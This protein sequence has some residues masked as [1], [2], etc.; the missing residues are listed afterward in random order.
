VTP[1]FAQSASDKAAAEALFD[2]GVKLLKAG[3]YDQAC[4]KLENSQR[5]DP[6]IGTLLYLGECYK[7]AGR[8]A[9][10]WAIF[11]EAASKAKAAGED[12]RARA[13][14]E[15][16]DALEGSLSRVTFKMADENK[17]IEGLEVH[18]GG[19]PV[20]RALWG[21]AV[22][23]DPGE[24]EVVVKAPGYEWFKT[25]VLVGEGGSTATL[26]I[27]ALVKLPEEAAEPEAEEAP[28]Q[29]PMVASTEDI[30]RPGSGQQLAGIIVG[31]I[32]VVGLGVGGAFGFLAMNKS[33]EADEFCD[34]ESCQAG[35]EGVSLTDQAR[36]NATISTIGFVAGGALLAGGA[37]LFLTAPSG[38]ETARFQLTPTVG[39]ARFT[40][41][42][43]F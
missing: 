3:K 34:G 11:R 37:V 25:I 41:G 7:K 12:E 29:A 2:D 28:T 19:E 16:A 36:T 4:E 42:T 10:A 5:I 21:S 40:A 13:G 43:K 8:T 23:V 9:S 27:P 32:G 31:S 6:G 18:Q 22:P 14:M 38:E 33:S 20:N 26:T 15:R 1:T 30:E 39:G 17:D 35:T 24:L